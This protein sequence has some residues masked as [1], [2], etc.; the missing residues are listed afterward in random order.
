[1][2][3]VQLSKRPLLFMVS[4]NNDSEMVILVFQ[5]QEFSQPFLNV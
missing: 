2:W 4:K 1:M 3:V 5:G